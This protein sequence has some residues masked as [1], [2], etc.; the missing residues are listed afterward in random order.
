MRKY[1]CEIGATVGFIVDK[2]L[3]PLPQVSQAQNVIL[4]LQYQDHH[5]DTIDSCMVLLATWVAQRSALRTLHCFHLTGLKSV[6]PQLHTVTST[7]A[8]NSRSSFFK[9]FLFQS[10][11]IVK[12]AFRI[13]LSPANKTPHKCTTAH[14]RIQIQSASCNY[15][16]DR[17]SR[18]H[19]VAQQM[20]IW[21][22]LIVVTAAA[23]P[24]AVSPSFDHH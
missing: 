8:P 18:A 22:A 16:L 17:T 1:F 7:A 14:C 6:S 5:R 2:I 19:L 23:N 13:S 4:Q 9:I 10:E 12:E 15:R 20:T 24:T 3:S 11:T 21:H